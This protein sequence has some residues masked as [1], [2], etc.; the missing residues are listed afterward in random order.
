MTLRNIKRTSLFVGE[1][2][3]PYPG[4]KDSGETTAVTRIAKKPEES[5]DHYR[6]FRKNIRV[7]QKP[8]F[9]Q[10]ELYWTSIDD[11]SIREYRK[12]KSGKHI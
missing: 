2:C 12:E 10:E 9:K 5:Q 6:I 11:Q 4:H 7:V 8:R 3:S 1:L